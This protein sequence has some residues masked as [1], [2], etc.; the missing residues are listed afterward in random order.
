MKIF[1]SKYLNTLHKSNLNISRKRNDIQLL[2]GVAVVGVVLNH[3]GLNLPGGFI[4]VDIFFVISGFFIASIINNQ[5]KSKNRITITDF[6][7]RRLLRLI[8]ALV[9]TSVFVCVSMIFLNNPSGAQQNAAKTALSTNF[10]L[11][12]YVI[13]Q[14]QNDYFANNSLYNPLLHYWTL[15]VEWQFYIIFPLLAMFYVKFIKGKFTRRTLIFTSIIFM[16]VYFYF[17]LARTSNNSDYFMITFRVWEFIAGITCT[18]LIKSKSLNKYVLLALRI[19]AYGALMICMLFIDKYS[20]LPGPV[21]FIPVLATFV[22]IYSGST[23]ITYKSYL[24][25]VLIHLGN[26]SYSIYL[27]HWP[28]FITVQYLSPN[29]PS[30]NLI[31]FGLTYL[32][33]LFTNKFIEEPFRTYDGN[34]KSATIF[35]SKIT[36]VNLLVSL[37]IGLLSSEIMNKY[38]G[39]GKLKTNISGDIYNFSKTK[40][41]NLK[42]C[43][44]HGYTVLYSIKCLP[45]VNSLDNSRGHRNILVIGDSHA[46]HL[47]NGLLHT[48][49][50]ANLNFIGTTSF[51]KV[52]D[53]Y[54]SDFNELMNSIKNQ[55]LVII[56]SF[57]NEFGINPRL[58]T[59]LQSLRQNNGEIFVDFDTPKFSFSSFRCK[60]GVSLFFSNRL[61]ENKREFSMNTEILNDLN[62][63]TASVSRVT[64]LHSYNAF[65]DEFYC[66]M[67]DNHKIYFYDSNHLNDLGSI[68]LIKYF[69]D[70]YVNFNQKEIYIK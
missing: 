29:I 22:L 16:M 26:M 13:Q 56:A 37:T 14:G 23:L 8:P 20:K 62:S 46:S 49:P 3:S 50:K 19:S 45:S 1:N 18:Y 28:I 61:C 9:F 41:L 25:K 27:W 43:A 70:N 21:L 30:K 64:P 39:E 38:V 69:T 32:F 7:I 42:E 63:L 68:Y 33:A 58:N 15:S 54:D 52:P 60:F 66:S 48:F 10:F 40:N 65:C 6:F 57:W 59:Y 51:H 4:G 53:N 17:F 34:L 67:S 35:L 31:Y 55:D 36:T 11:G 5:Y 12:N 47:I 24:S 44:F 2:R